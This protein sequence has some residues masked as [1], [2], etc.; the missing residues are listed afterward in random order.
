MSSTYPATP[1][2]NLQFPEPGIKFAAV[3]LSFGTVACPS[4]TWLAP[5]TLVART[6]PT[7][8]DLAWVQQLDRPYSFHV[9]NSDCCIVVSQHSDRPHILDEESSF[10]QDRV[11]AAYLALTLM[12][13]PTGSQALC[14]TGGNDSGVVHV[15]QYFRCDDYLPARGLQ[16]ADWTLQS[17]RNASSM[18]AALGSFKGHRRF[19]RGVKCV[20]EALHTR[21]LCH[22]LH[23]HVRAIEAL[24]PL[25]S[26]EGCWDFAE[27]LCDLATYPTWGEK[28]LERKPKNHVRP[29]QVGGTTQRL[30]RF[31]DLYVLRSKIEHLLDPN[32]AR[33]DVSDREFARYIA[34]E[35]RLAERVAFGLYQR[36]L[37]NSDLLRIFCD[38]ELLTE[39]WNRSPEDRRSTWG[40]Q[41]RADGRCSR[42]MQGCS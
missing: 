22:R 35:C 33:P 40:L 37:L 38:K 10:L 32:D 18:Y 29:Y 9:E 13:G 1:L 21:D 26:R 2:P 42:H 25:A 36:I 20:L 28:S 16:S 14:I 23:N 12:C 15:P 6:S 3:F 4:S 11:L 41:V 39:F 27:R 5:D 17:M 19:N 24:I 8:G 30:Q 31:E 7:I 34:S